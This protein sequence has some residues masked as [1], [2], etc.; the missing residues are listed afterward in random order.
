MGSPIIADELQ[1]N[2]NQAYVERKIQLL[3]TPIY[4]V[5]KKKIRPVSVAAL[6][7]P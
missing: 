4:G 2:E 6:E 3:K 5:S 7:E 1:F